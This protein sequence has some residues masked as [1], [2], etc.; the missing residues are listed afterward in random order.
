[1]SGLRLDSELEP[2]SYGFAPGVHGRGPRPR[3]VQHTEEPPEPQRSRPVP[4]FLLDDLSALTAGKADDEFVFTAP[5]GGVLRLRN[6]RHAVFAPAAKAI[7][8]PDRT[9]HALRHTAASLVIAAGANVKV[10]PG[11]ACPGLSMRARQDS[12]LQ[13]LDP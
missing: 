8:R 12:N 7:G 5:Q 11:V 13:P 4:R 10:A 6:F 9:P 1:M 3:R 2:A